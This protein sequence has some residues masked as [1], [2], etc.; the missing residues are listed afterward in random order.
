[1]SRSLLIGGVTLGQNLVK[2]VGLA[3]LQARN[4]MEKHLTTNAFLEAAPF[5][6]INLV[7]RYGE[8]DLWHPEIGSIDTRNGEL[9]VAIQFDSDAL[10]RMSDPERRACFFRALIEVLCDIAANYDLPYE[11][12]DEL[13]HR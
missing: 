4:E 10:N 13:R 12:M 9:P 3:V 8:K 11:F 5:K 1:M 6:T 7:F 2:D